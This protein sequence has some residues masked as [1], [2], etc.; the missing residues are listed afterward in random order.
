MSLPTNPSEQQD[1]NIAVVN[2]EDKNKKAMKPKVTLPRVTTID[3]GDYKKYLD[4]NSSVFAGK[5]LGILVRDKSEIDKLEQD[6]EIITIII[7][8]DIASVRP[9]FLEEFLKDVVLL[10]G[11]KG[12]Q[13]K[14]HFECK[15]PSLYEIDDDLEEAVDCIIPQ[16]AYT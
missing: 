2:V 4:Q 9:S 8:G 10:L 13:D 3:L 15:N 1:E 6:H 5:E 12:F 7:P 16:I 14:F 11:R